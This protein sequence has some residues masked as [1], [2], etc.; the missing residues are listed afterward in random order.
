M[1]AQVF[2][3]VSYSSRQ[4]SQISPTADFDGAAISLPIISMVPL[5][6]IQQNR[7]IGNPDGGAGSVGRQMMKPFFICG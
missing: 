2:W 1:A 6:E 3:A 4:P 7:L 5:C